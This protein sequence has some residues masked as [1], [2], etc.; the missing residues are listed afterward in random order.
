MYS[1]FED[2]EKLLQQVLYPPTQEAPYSIL[3][4]YAPKHGMIPLLLRELNEAIEETSNESARG[5]DGY[6]YLFLKRIFH[7]KVRTVLHTMYA[8][9]VEARHHPAA[10]KEACVV[11]LQKPNKPNYSNPKSY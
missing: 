5:S 9:L 8:K 6:T 7:G 1:S 10:W 2:K 4:D 3:A 11:I